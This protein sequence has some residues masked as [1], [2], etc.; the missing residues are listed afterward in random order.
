[1]VIHLNDPTTGKPIVPPAIEPSEAVPGEPTFETTGY[2]SGVAYAGL[3]A[4]GDATG[5]KAY[6]DFVAKRFQFF[7][8]TMPQ[9]TDAKGRNI[10]R[11]WIK[12]VSLDSCGAIG[13]AMI[14]AR[15]ANIGPDF[16]PLIDR[17]ADFVSH[18][19]YR[20]DDG[21]V[22]RKNPFPDSIW[23]DDMYMSVPLLAQMGAL[24]NDKSYF[25]DAAKQVTQLSGYLFVPS[26]NLYTHGW[27]RAIGKNQP[28]Y[29]WGRAN[30]WCAMATVELLDVLPQ[31]HPKRDEIIKLLN[32]HAQG[33]ASTQSGN[34]LWHQMLDRPD[35]FMETSASAMFTFA[36]A[37]GVNHG[38]LDADTY[39]PVALA[40][41]NGL[42]TKI[43]AHG[44]VT[45][46]CVGTSYA[47]DY[48]YYYA[49][50]A[51]D[52]IHGYGPVLLAGSEIIKMIKTLHPVPTQGHG[53]PVMMRGNTKPPEF[54]NDRPDAPK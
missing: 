5:D 24:T 4:A 15:R 12:P 26:S 20:L 31:D 53:S 48:A 13:A 2:P 23:G 50:T 8:D 29:Y 18:K 34:G 52:D 43:D 10:F 3:L 7:H 51:T 14:K 17:F 21:T 28:H 25:D 35:S 36:I 54:T 45:G 44:H 38:W 6:T 41:W 22:A 27:H 40:G 11:A 46:T 39:G 9:F 1:M 16:K 47:S 30:G 49:R 37:N 19:Q 33:L 32:A 42:T